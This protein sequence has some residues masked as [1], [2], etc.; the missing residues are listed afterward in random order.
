MKTISSRLLFR[1]W[2]RL[3]KPAG[4]A[5][6][7]LALAGCPAGN[8]SQP[9]A[10]GAAGKVVIKGS[11]TIGEEIAPRLAREFKKEHATAVIEIESKGTAYGFGNLL[12]G[13]C[14]IAAA[15]RL[16]NETEMGLAKDRGIELSEQTVGFYSVAVVLNAANPV[17]DLTKEQVRDIFTGVIKNWKDV[18]GPDAGIHLYVRDPVSGTHLGFLELAME[19]KPY[20][21]GFKAVT[22]YADMMKAVAAD[23]HGVGYSDIQLAGNPGI[24]AASIGGVAPTVE[25]V[26]NGKYPYRRG[27]HLYTRKGGES[28]ETKAFLDFIQSKR[29]LEIRNELGVVPPL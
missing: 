13:G 12:S 14:D 29:G 28:A 23:A 5:L 19:G 10:P 20:G 4:L 7:G 9:P 2:I 1:A 16:P 3:C 18:G 27:L 25:L 22:S 26:N 15:S 24:K 17:S 21:T 6:T 11:N 8:Q